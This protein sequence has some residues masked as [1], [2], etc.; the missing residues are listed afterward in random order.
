MSVRT[1]LIASIGLGFI[2]CG[3]ES[4]SNVPTTTTPTTGSPTSTTG[5]GGSSSSADLPVVNTISSGPTCAMVS[6]TKPTAAFA[7]RVHS[8][9]PGATTWNRLDTGTCETSVVSATDVDCTVTVPEAQLFFSRLYF[10]VFALN[11]SSQCDVI[12]FSPYSY[13]AEG[14]DTTTTLGW[15]TAEV[16]CSK[17][18]DKIECWNGAGKHL[19]PSFP[20]NNRILHTIKDLAYPTWCSGTMVESGFQAQK[21]FG[22]NR[23]I[24][25][26]LA[27]GLRAAPRTP[28]GLPDGYVANSMVDW[29]WS[30]ADRFDDIQYSIRMTITD[31]DG[32]PNTI[33]SWTGAT[34]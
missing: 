34:F 25:N 28:L 8:R 27:A 31:S 7:V 11:G 30:C 9:W 17:P 18:L 10:E 32:A 21:G 1:L 19:V 14:I 12:Y 16:D 24:T 22:T 20:R 33:P 26:D 2:G 3:K 5:S 13:L 23:Y 15:N 6:A 29:R 4:T